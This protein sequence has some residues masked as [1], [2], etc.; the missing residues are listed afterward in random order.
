MAAPRYAIYFAPPPHSPW[1]EF[2]TR[3]LGRDEVSKAARAQ[4]CVAGIDTP[5]LH[6][7]TAAP[8]RYG[9]HATLKAPFR[10]RPVIDETALLARVRALA[11]R[12]RPVMLTPLIAR[13][14]D[15][16]VALMPDTVPPRL[17]EIEAA[18]VTELDDLRAPLTETELA[19]RRA[20]GLDARA[21]ELLARYGYPH[22]LDRFRLHFT[23]TDRIGEAEAALVC[24]AVRDLVQ[25]LN[26]TAALMLDRL[27]V[28]VEPQLGRDLLRVTDAALGVTCHRQRGAG[29]T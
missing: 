1:W 10:L 12:L 28:F 25:H 18:C 13:R 29:E 5:R 9:F 27:C 3:W 16:F 4:P 20:A 21:E 19:A 14:I 24:D 26:N 15:G 17:A 8:R 11:A 23:L 6:V 22:V 2:G 7:L